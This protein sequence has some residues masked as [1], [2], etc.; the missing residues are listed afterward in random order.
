MSFSFD[1]TDI[2]DKEEAEMIYRRGLTD[3][4]WEFICYNLKSK[5]WPRVR[6]EVKELLEYSP[7]A[8]IKEV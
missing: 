6:K 3:K 1:L 7:D 8:F 2:F 4:E 5:L